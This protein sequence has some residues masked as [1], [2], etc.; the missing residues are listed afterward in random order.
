MFVVWVIVI[1][2]M[3]SG[4]L[5]DGLMVYWLVTLCPTVAA[6]VRLLHDVGRSGWWLALYFVPI[7]GALVLLV[8]WALPS[9][10]AANR[11]GPPPK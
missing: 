11:W 4:A 1:L 6:A 5:I 2:E 3:E 9:Q 10:H 8:L 7:L